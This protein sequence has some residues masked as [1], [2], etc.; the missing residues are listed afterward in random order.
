MAKKKDDKGRFDL[1]KGETPKA[2]S[3]KGFDLGK[4]E[5][6]KADSGKGFDL[7]KGEASKA[8]SGNGSA[9][10]A[11]KPTTG[12]K[13][14]NAGSG[15]AGG[16]SEGKEAGG[17][18]SKKGKVILLS[19]LGIAAA[20]LIGY[21]LMPKDATEPQEGLIAGVDS[22]ADGISDTKEAELGTDPNNADSDGD[23]QIDGAEF[24]L[25]SNP[26]DGD[27]TYE[28]SDGDGLSDAYEAENNLD[29]NNKADATIDSDIDGLNNFKEMLLGSNPNLADTDSDGQNDASELVFGSNLNDASDKYLDSDN[30]GLSDSFEK[31]NS[32][33]PDDAKDG[34]NNDNS[35]GTMKFKTLIAS[36]NS[37][38]AKNYVVMNKGT[39][40]D[41]TGDLYY[42]ASGSSYIDPSNSKLIE[43]RDELK[44]NKSKTISIIGHTDNTGDNDLN[45]NLS[46]ARAQSIVSYLIGQG[47]ESNRLNI[48]GK[49]E[50]APKYTNDN[51]EGRRQNRRVEITN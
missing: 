21:F 36:V 29:A 41:I 26:N 28:D 49:G 31:D 14:S 15:N 6:P 9:P 20:C 33:D 24:V 48:V 19:L 51:E 40:K 2:D 4:G 37:K 23:G 25:G 42:F 35:K 46:V 11:V 43:L 18:G 50:N 16:N 22:D 32:Q 13:G 39:S 7:G 45:Q 12:A 8:D 1:G 27:D 10:I 30:D 34:V 47:V 38:E 17:E 5:A 3:G 44:R